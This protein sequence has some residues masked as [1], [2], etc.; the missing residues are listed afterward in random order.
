MLKHNMK[1]VLIAFRKKYIKLNVYKGFIP[2][3]LN[4]WD[5]GAQTDMAMSKILWICH[6]NPPTI[7]RKCSGCK[8]CEGNGS[9][10]DP[11]QGGET[12]VFRTIFGWC[13][14]GPIE[15]SVNYNKK[16]PYYKVLEKN[17]G[18]K[19]VA[20]HHFAIEKSFKEINTEK[21]LQSI[22]QHEY[23]KPQ[24]SNEMIDLIDPNN[25]ISTENKCFLQL[26]KNKTVMVNRNYQI[27]FLCM[28]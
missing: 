14:V 21:M 17:V 3:D 28:I 13:T 18:S 2:W 27:S 9:Q 23:T 10:Q 11:N 8:Y 19:K 15:K 25:G 12:Y 1:A 6:C 22:Y 26:M 20:N 5:L 4:K 16:L 7:R 24:V